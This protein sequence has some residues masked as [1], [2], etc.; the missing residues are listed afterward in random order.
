[1]MQSPSISWKFLEAMQAL[2][3]QSLVTQKVQVADGSVDQI[4]LS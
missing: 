2:V 3:P 4:L 1:M